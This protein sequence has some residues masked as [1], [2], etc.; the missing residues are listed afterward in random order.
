MIRDGKDWINIVNI[1]KTLCALTFGIMFAYLLMQFRN[2]MVYFDDYGYYSLSYGMSDP[3]GSTHFSLGGLF[4]FLYMHYKRLN[5]R[6][7]YFFIWLLIYW[8]GDLTL[9][10]IVAAFVTTGVLVAI[11]KYI[12]NEHT[13]V[14]SAICMCTLYGF[15]PIELHQHGTYWMAAFFHYV[16]PI[17][18]LMVFLYIYT[19]YRASGFSKVQKYILAV[20]V[21]CSAFSQEQLSVAVLFMTILILVWDTYEKRQSVLNYVLIVIALVCVAILMLSPGIHRRASTYDAPLFERILNSTEQVI[22]MFFSNRMKA[23]VLILWCSVTAI[24]IFL[25][26][27]EKGWL[28]HFID[29][30]SIILGCFSIMTYCNSEIQS[31]MIKFSEDDTCLILLGML[32][33]VIIYVQVF[34]FYCAKN[35]IGRL[36]V[37]STAVASVGCLSFVPEIPWRLLLPS[38][39]LLFPVLIDGMAV[40]VH[41]LSN[42]KLKVFC[43]IILCIMLPC[44]SFQNVSKIYQGYENN[45]VVHQYND[46]LMR[47]YAE[48]ETDTGDVERIYLKELPDSRYSGVMVYD[49]D[50][51]GPMKRWMMNYYGIKSNPDLCFST[52]GKPVTSS[53]E[54]YTELGNGVY[55]KVKAITIEKIHPMYSEEGILTLAVECDPIYR[56]CQIEVNGTVYPTTVGDTFISA[57]ITEAEM[58]LSVSVVVPHMN[59]R[60][61]YVAVE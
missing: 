25:F 58:P 9:V 35:E 26:K 27:T 40:C 33:V 2:V 45:F 36:I 21:F 54:F 1:K 23:F 13:M 4:E 30:F 41:L 44:F 51:R 61:D 52:D 18:P 37:F 31:F 59:L 60:S 43:C 3:H 22:R 10:R 49:L 19:K 28:C 14:S 15:L 34:R 38:W 7:L 17:L 8:I 29:A 50:E 39:F 12:A 5:G 56:D 47:D 57:V 48:K 6:L 20:M 16:A 32:L 42:K 11:W 24:S 46:A 55:R 53:D